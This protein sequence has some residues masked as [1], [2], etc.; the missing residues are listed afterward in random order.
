MKDLREFNNLLSRGEMRQV[1]GGEFKD[2]G[3]CLTRCTT[4][5]DCTYHNCKVCHFFA[6]QGSFCTTN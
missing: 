1:Q 5:S 3:G 2:G 4:A 6:G